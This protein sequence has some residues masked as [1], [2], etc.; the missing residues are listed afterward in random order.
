VSWTT[1][2]TDCEV[3]WTGELEFEVEFQ[4]EFD[5]DFQLAGMEFFK[6]ELAE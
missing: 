5:L 1:W 3:N 6:K 2:E 4:L